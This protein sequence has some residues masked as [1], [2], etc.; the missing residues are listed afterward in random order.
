M[1]VAFDRQHKWFIEFIVAAVVK[2]LGEVV[3]ELSGIAKLRLD[4]ERLVHARAAAVHHARMDSGTAVN[5]VPLRDDRNNAQ[6]KEQGVE[7]RH[8][9]AV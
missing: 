7:H 4:C 3:P 5:R 8:N 1:K 9:F 6:R 2:L